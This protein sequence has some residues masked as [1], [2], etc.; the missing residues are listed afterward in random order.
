MRFG[1]FLSER[2]LINNKELEEL[3]LVAR[4]H[5]K[6]IGRLAVELGY[7]NNR[8]L[9]AVLIE[10][11]NP[12]CRLSFN[13]LKELYQERSL[14]ESEKRIEAECGVLIISSSAEQCLVLAPEFSDHLV[15]KLED[16]TGKNIE[17]QIVD[18]RYL[19]LLGVK[20]AAKVESKV[21][22]AKTI[23][24]DTKLSDPNPYGRL[25]KECFEEAKKSGVSDIHFEPYEQEYCIRFRVHG[26]LIDWKKLAREHIQ[27]L[28]S[29]LK[30]LI[31]M[32]LAI[33][34]KPQ[35]SRATFHT[36]GIDLRAS[37][38]PVASGCE[39]VVLRL[40]YHGQTFDIRSLGL[41]AKKLGVL[42]ESIQKSD[43]L[44]L[45]SGPTGSGKTTTLYALLEE[46]DRLG[47]N[48]STLENPVE[49]HLPRI[50]QANVKDHKDFE[51]FQRALMRQD[52]DI[53]LLGE[54]RDPETAD[55]SM[56][57]SSTGHLVLSTVHAN[58]AVEV[59]DRLKNLGIDTFSIQSNLRLSVAQRLVKTLCP[60]CRKSAPAGLIRDQDLFEFKVVNP[61]GCDS[62]QRGISGRKAVIEYI[63]RAQLADMDSPI[64]VEDS[65]F[66]ECMNLAKRGEI[67]LRDALS[68]A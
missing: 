46:M 23:D 19:E 38:M 30:H 21:V 36:L 32:D 4:F 37:S 25:L 35:D 3:V 31:N 14:S 60:Y 22:V 34:G 47:K 33:V 9:D 7:L 15:R 27:P 45:I 41:S 24:D 49:K 6:K 55:L 42:L 39:K 16:A 20:E 59:I 11:L 13:D 28:T 66:D 18:R 63:D 40:Q 62:C 58:G 48:I 1:E 17:L 29:R 53:I 50:N 5:R 51:N 2:G 56:K 54:I 10:Y 67:D 52:P 68:Y 64:R 61:D 12:R 65:L 44:V 8:Q 57:L 26:Q 43:G